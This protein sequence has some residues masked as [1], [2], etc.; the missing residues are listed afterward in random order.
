MEAENLLS[1]SRVC[2]RIR[3]CLR[4]S[5]FNV[6]G[7][8]AISVG[9]IFALTVADVTFYFHMR[10]SITHGQ[11]PWYSLDC[12]IISIG[13]FEATMA[14]FWSWFCRRKIKVLATTCLLPMIASLFLWMLPAVPTSKGSEF[15]NG[16]SNGPVSF[17]GMSTA[18]AV[19]L[20]MFIFAAALHAVARSAVWNHS[21]VI[22]QENDPGKLSIH[23]G[24]LVTARV[25]GLMMFS[26][27]VDEFGPPWALWAAIVGPG[28]VHG[29]QYWRLPEP[30]PKQKDG[31]LERVQASKAEV[32]PCWLVVGQ[33]LA[34]GLLV[35]SLWGYMWHLKDIQK[36][37][38][39][40]VEDRRF[41]TNMSEIIYLVTI[42]LAVAVCGLKSTKRAPKFK[43][44]SAMKLAATL[45]VF[46]AVLYS[47][48]TMV[49][50]CNPGLVA[51]VSPRQYYTQPACSAHC[52]CA[53]P[54]SEFDPVCITDTMTT[55]LSP[56][57]AGC[58]ASDKLGGLSVYS[59][60]TCAPGAGSR[61]AAVG[62]C[63]AVQCR[64]A[65]ILHKAVT[66]VIVVLTVV[67]LQAH[68][69]TL[70][71]SVRQRYQ[72][73][74]IG[75]VTS[76]TL[77]LTFGCGHL[78]YTAIRAATCTWFEGGRCLLHS[79]VFLKALGV[80]STGSAAVSAIISIAIWVV[81]RRASR[82]STTDNIDL[83]RNN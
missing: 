13:L 33:I 46:V 74:A 53:V 36:M 41:I 14:V 29:F 4:A 25:L 28:V 35:S 62:A 51:G 79:P 48:Q 38:F 47:V 16:I 42:V 76:V 31:D 18:G 30:V 82:N 68:L 26:R 27:V 65:F 64:S 22:F 60:C 23:Y 52:G 77:L 7:F 21:L 43:K 12:L 71:K 73:T 37:S 15:C 3:K 11:L 81:L 5:G 40:V 59:N 9:M 34:V 75:S 57:H 58:Q 2:Q 80:V 83:T 55:Y 67:S 72:A 44:D 49:L 63:G 10:H 69:V 32:L 8:R 50:A 54:Y 61:R 70:V 20:A 17:Q 6:P 39:Y 78:V 66:I 24:T 45:S 56:C 19:R 1:D